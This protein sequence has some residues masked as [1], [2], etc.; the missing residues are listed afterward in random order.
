MFSMTEILN[1]KAIV[2]NSMPTIPKD[3]GSSSL[4]KI[5]EETHWD[6]IISKQK[7]FVFWLRTLG[8]LIF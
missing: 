1:I 8:K 5:T 6:V 2:H 7:Q 3:L 4:E